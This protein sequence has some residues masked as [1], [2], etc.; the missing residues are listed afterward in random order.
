MDGGD[1]KKSFSQ[2]LVELV[3]P[4][5]IAPKKNEIKPVTVSKPAVNAVK[6]EK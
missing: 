3:E 2:K 4:V 5:V 1:K 6:K